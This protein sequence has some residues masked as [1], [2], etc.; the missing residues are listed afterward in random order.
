MWIVPHCNVLELWHLDSAAQI[1]LFDSKTLYLLIISEMEEED[2]NDIVMCGCKPCKF[3]TRRRHRIAQDR[4]SKYGTEE[5]RQYNAWI[6]AE[7]Q[8]QGHIPQPDMTP[9]IRASSM[10]HREARRQAMAG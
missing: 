8:G 7:L 6:D 3:Q 1:D 2:S 5:I 10:H 9:D 4:V